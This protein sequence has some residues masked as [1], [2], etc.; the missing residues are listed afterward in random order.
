MVGSRFRRVPSRTLLLLFEVTPSDSLN[1]I[2]DPQRFWEGNQN[3]RHSQN[4]FPPS[5]LPGDEKAS[6]LAGD[7]LQWLQL[8]LPVFQIAAII[9]YKTSW[10]PTDIYLQESPARDLSENSK[11]TLKIKQTCHHICLGSRAQSFSSTLRSKCHQRRSEAA[12]RC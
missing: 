3:H 9:Y 1:D 8:F 4:A 6:P 2:G 7:V 12:S 11:K 10:L 5:F